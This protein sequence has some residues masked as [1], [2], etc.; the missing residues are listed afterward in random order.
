MYMITCRNVKQVQ[1]QLVLKWL[2]ANAGTKYGTAHNFSQ[3]KC[4]QDFKEQHPL[5][6]H[7]HYESYIDNVYQGET[8]V[9]SP[10][11]PYILA[12]T[13][14]TSGMSPNI[15]STCWCPSASARNQ[16]R[17]KFIYM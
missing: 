17:D 16:R 7:Q 14:G 6:Y 5:T 9:M 10:K 4:V 13:S 3:I 2:G 8:N 1:E 11:Q 15:C 12:M